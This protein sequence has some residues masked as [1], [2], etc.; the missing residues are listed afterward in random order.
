MTSIFTTRLAGQPGTDSAKTPLFLSADEKDQRDSLHERNSS[1]NEKRQSL[2]R[3]SQF[4]SRLLGLSLRNARR[5][6]PGLFCRTHKSLR[7][8]PGPQIRACLL[9][10]L[11]ILKFSRLKNS[12]PLQQSDDQNDQGDDQKNVDQAATDMEREKPQSPQNDQDDYNCLKHADLLFFFCLSLSCSQP[13]W[14]GTM[15]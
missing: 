2:L 7:R 1:D 8:T 4:M 13:S 15:D 14:D 11:L 5:D 12:P 3:W 6:W 9:I 10:R